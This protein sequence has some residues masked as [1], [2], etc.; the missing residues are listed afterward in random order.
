MTRTVGALGE[1]ERPRPAWQRLAVRLPRREAG[2]VGKALMGLGATGL[3]EDLPP[4]A[5]RVFRQPWDK[6][7]RPRPPPEVLLYAWF[8]ERPADDAV[9]EAVGREVEW[10]EEAE[11]DWAESWKASF[12]PVR[13]SERLVVAAPW[14]GL[15]GALLIEPGLA[16]GTGE[17][18]TTRACLRAIDSFAQ[19]GARLLDVGCG[20]GILA[21]AGAKLG[22]RATGVDIDP[23]AVRAAR[24]AAVANGLEAE[25]STTPLDELAGEWDLVVANLFAEVLVAL[26]PA[27]LARARGPVALA[28]ILADR[29]ALVRAAFADRPLLG[30]EG[31]GD[32]VSLV[33]GPR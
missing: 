27:I 14:H 7:R 5:P 2:A 31:D 19:P 16:F 33:Y 13:I 12:E 8:A 4:E 30:E 32:W 28:G 10:S 21:L 24:E 29:A 6:G 15:E 3:Q 11:T 9:R 23:E 22:M 26:A 20:S 1:G 17:H 18:P 25:F